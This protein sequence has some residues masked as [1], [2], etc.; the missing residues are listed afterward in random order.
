MTGFI[1][2]M[3]PM[4]CWTPKGS[5]KTKEEAEKALQETEK[6]DEEVDNMMDQLRAAEDELAKKK[7]EADRDMMMAG[8]VRHDSHA[9]L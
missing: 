8:M 5:A 7:S 1:L 3:P 2:L 9:V 4:F 6:L